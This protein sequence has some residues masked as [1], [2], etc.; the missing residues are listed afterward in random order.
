MIRLWECPNNNNKSNCLIKYEET[1]FK[2]VNGIR[3]DSERTKNEKVFDSE[4]TY[5]FP[6]MIKTQKCLTMECF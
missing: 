1:L 4:L 6:S 3:T 2:V 5:K